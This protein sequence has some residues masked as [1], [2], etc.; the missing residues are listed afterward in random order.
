[1]K[2]LKYAVCIALVVMSPSIFA[3]N[4]LKAKQGQIVTIERDAKNRADRIIK[5]I[6]GAGG[7]NWINQLGNV[8]SV[9]DRGLSDGAYGWGI[10]FLNKRKRDLAEFQTQYPFAKADAQRIQQAMN[11]Y[12]TALDKAKA[13][14]E[15][16]M[17]PSKKSEEKKEEPKKSYTEVLQEVG[18]EMRARD[19]E[20]ETVGGDSFDAHAKNRWL[21]VVAYAQDKID[22]LNNPEAAGPNAELKKKAYAAYGLTVARNSVKIDEEVRDVINYLK[23]YIPISEAVQYRF[24]FWRQEEGFINSRH[25][26]GKPYGQWHFLMFSALAAIQDLSSYSDEDA[27]EMCKQYAIEADKLDRTGLGDQAAKQW[28]RLTDIHKYLPK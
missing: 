22:Q 5:D 7:L 3:M 28:N 10:D 25:P 2:L 20:A 4:A 11:E 6:T 16:R 8:K 13:A 21:H 26:A 24:D 19:T 15:V 23:Q 12:K 17:N 27:Q 14:A 1:M 9:L 18:Q